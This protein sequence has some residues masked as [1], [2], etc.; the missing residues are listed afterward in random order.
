MALEW[1]RRRQVL[2]GVGVVLFF[3]V[4][5]VI[6]YFVFVYRAPSCMDGIQ[7]QDEAGIDC[8]GMCTTMCSPPRVDQLWTRSVKVA[9]GV[10]H[11]VAFVKNP[12]PDYRGT[13]IAYVISLYDVGNI[14]V[15]ERRGTVTLEPG[16]SRA[17]FEPN[18]ITGSRIPV[19]TLTKLDGGNWDKAQPITNPIRIVTQELDSAGLNLTATL[20]NTTA[21]VVNDVVADAL[22]YDADDILIAASE[23][24]LASIPARGRHD[25]TFTWV[26]AFTKPVARAD[27]EVRSAHAPT[28]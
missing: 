1:A 8:D 18:V 5:A 19:R 24:R 7:N 25:I 21:V 9:D 11:T 17:I 2:Y 26:V 10:Y 20:E 14:L 27:I 23:T 28:P 22:L 4:I 12:K 6:I 13:N 3:L 15:A 16:E